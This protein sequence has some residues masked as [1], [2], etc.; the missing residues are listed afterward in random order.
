MNTTTNYYQPPTYG[1]GYGAPRPQARN[2]QP[3]TPEQIQ[4][5][6]QD[7]NAFDMKVDVEDIWRAVCTH[8][9]KTTGAS[10]LV[11]NND[12]SYTCTIC[13]ETFHMCDCS[14]EEIQKAVD[15]IIDMLQTC[16]TIYLDASEDLIAQYMQQIALI[17]KFPG[18]WKRAIQNFSMYENTLNGVNQIGAGYSGFN[19]MQSLLTNPYAAYGQPPYN[20]YPAPQMPMQPY[21]YAPQMGMPSAAPVVDPTA[22]P[23]AYGVPAATPVSAP[24]AAPAPGVMPAAPAPAPASA[25]AAT[26]PANGEVQQQQ[27]FNV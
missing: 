4:K 21:G 22:N 5:L 23:M 26:A 14:E 9:E 3:L 7:S 16:K 20:Q 25:P 24:V 15:T 27:V 10:T 1:Y 18:L 2:T 12:G 17:K 13:H 8:K 19:A 11:Q 6:R